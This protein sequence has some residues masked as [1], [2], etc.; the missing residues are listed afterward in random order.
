M[1]DLRQAFE[2]R[3][4]IVPVTPRLII[5]IAL[6]GAVLRLLRTYS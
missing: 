5:V 3:K 2:V 1:A 6:T 4:R